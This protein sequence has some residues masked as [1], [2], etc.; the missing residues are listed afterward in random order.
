MNITLSADKELIRRA[1]EAARRQ[2]KSLNEVVRQYL[3]ALAAQHEGEVSSDHLF[4]LMDEG[5][6]DLA[7]AGWSRN[8]IHER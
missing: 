6:G 3:Q 1:R 5:N 2:G 8:E 7:G 4:E